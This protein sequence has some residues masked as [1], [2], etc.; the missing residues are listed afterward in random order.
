MNSQAPWSAT[1]KAGS[2]TR[3]FGQIDAPH[4]T[5]VLH[6]GEARVLEMLRHCTRLGVQAGKEMPER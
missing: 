4:T 5:G 6:R 2:L 3:L 1:F